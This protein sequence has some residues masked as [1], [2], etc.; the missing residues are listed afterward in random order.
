MADNVVV[1]PGSGGAIIA[2]D[3]I[4]GVWYPKTKIVFGANDA[5]TD[6]ES[7]APFPVLGWWN[8]AK[9]GTGTNLVPLL[10]SD[11]H[12]QVDILSDPVL[13]RT[14]DAVAVALQTDAMM[15]G[16]TALTPKYKIIDA[17]LSGNNTLVAAVSGKKLRVLSVFLMAAAA[18]VVRFEDGAG[19]T[20]LSG[21]M[22]VAV[23]GGF[24]MPFNPVGWFE[25]SSNVLLNLELDGAVSVDGCLV[26]VEV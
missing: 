18:V 22:N 21:Q 8:T 23:N 4:G 15:N 7:S 16:A 9:D 10:D 20:A 24:V 1:N 2:A 6:V 13:V 5:F 3:D 19:G 25:T 17:A 12:P 14:T 26:Y 11:G